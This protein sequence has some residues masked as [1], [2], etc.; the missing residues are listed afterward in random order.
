M[1]E[2]LVFLSE[3]I[4][5]SLFA[6]IF[7]KSKQK[8]YECPTPQDSEDQN[9]TKHSANMIWVDELGLG[10]NSDIVQFVNKLF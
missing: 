5:C 4:N 2:L 3:S 1:S 8:T 10:G 6:H 9:V 7:A